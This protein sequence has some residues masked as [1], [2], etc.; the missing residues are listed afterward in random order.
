MAPHDFH[1]S[2]AQVDIQTASREVQITLHIFLDDLEDALAQR[3]QTQ[4]FLGT[5]KEKADA[6]EQL[7]IYLKDQ[8]GLRSED[9][10]LEFELIGKEMSEDLAAI[11]CYLLVSEVPEIRQVVVRNEILMELYDD[12]KNLI[13]VRLDGESKDFYMLQKGDVSRSVRLN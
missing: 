9:L 10:D 11:W 13:H 7:L 2:K 12:Q 6:E 1:V 3:G 4:L 5:Q 8:F